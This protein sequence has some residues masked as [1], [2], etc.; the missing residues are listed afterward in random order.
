MRH[1]GVLDYPAAGQEKI[2]PRQRGES[3]AVRILLPCDSGP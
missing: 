3:G 1:A 2:T